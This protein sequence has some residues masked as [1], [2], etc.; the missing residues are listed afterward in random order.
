MKKWM[1]AIAVLFMGYGANAQNEVLGEWFNDIKSSKLQVYEENGMYYGKVIWLERTT[2]LDGTSPRTDE[3]N[4]D[5]SLHGEKLMGKVILQG[6]KW[7]SS[8][9]EWQEGTIYDPKSGKTYECYCA[10][11]EDGSLYFKGYIM[12]ITWLGKSTVWTRN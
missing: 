4:P 1:L 10:M 8:D 6:L 9:K 2:N 7:N 12:G 3:I 5:E 11:Q